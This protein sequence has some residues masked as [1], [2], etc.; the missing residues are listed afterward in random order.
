[1]EEGQHDQSTSDYPLPDV[2]Y[3]TVKNIIQL[4]DWIRELEQTNIGHTSAH[5]LICPWHFALW[6]HHR[7]DNIILV[8]VLVYPQVVLAICWIVN[9]IHYYVANNF[10]LSFRGG[11]FWTTEPR[12]NFSVVLSCLNSAVDLPIVRYEG[13]SKLSVFIMAPWNSMDLG[14]IPLWRYLNHCFF[15]LISPFYPNTQTT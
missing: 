5:G 3:N 4:P 12:V 9:I 2:G 14:V 10:N 11:I 7:Y 13:Q 6:W 1:M 8:Q 15:P